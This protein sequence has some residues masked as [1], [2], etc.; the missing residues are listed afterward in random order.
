MPPPESRPNP[1]PGGSSRAVAAP[2]GG[3]LGGTRMH[4][5]RASAVNEGAESLARGNIA[6]LGSGEAQAGA[7]TT[8]AEGCAASY[9][10]TSTASARMQTPSSRK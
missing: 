10:R 3:P 2:L 1:V 6:A 4:A 7:L 8:P 5:A 9:V